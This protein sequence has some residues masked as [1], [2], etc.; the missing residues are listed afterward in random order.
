MKKGIILLF[1]AFLILSCQKDEPEIIGNG[2][3][4]VAEA[5]I[6]INEVLAE[7]RVV[8]SYE[9]INNDYIFSLVGGSS[10]LVI[11]ADIVASVE[12]Q[13]QQW[14]LTI[15]FT[16]GENCDLY[17]LGDSLGLSSSNV[18]LNPAG[19]SPLS[20]YASFETPFVGKI[21]VV[22]PG[23]TTVGISM[24]HTYD[25][26]TSDYDELPILGLYHSYSNPVEFHFLDI[27]ENLL[28][29]DTVDI[30]TQTLTNIPQFK[31]IQNNLPADE[32]MVYMEI[33]S[34]HAFDQNGDLRW[35]Y[36]NGPANQFFDRMPDG[37]W[38]V[39]SYRD[40]V[41]YHWPHFFEMDMFGRVIEEYEIPN[42]G[43]HEIRLADDANTFLI[44]S[45]SHKMT[46]G[47]FGDVGTNQEDVII[48]ISRETGQVSRSYDLNE[49][50]DNTRETLI[51][52]T[53][54]WFHANS[55]VQDM[56]AD[57]I[58]GTIDDAIIVSGRHQGTVAKINRSFGTLQWLISAHEGWGP[59]HQPY[60]LTPV[61]ESGSPIDISNINF[62]PYGQHSAILLPN[63]NVFVYDN[64]NNRGFYKENPKPENQ[65]SRAVEYKV[66]EEN[67][68]VEKVWEF[69]YNRQIFTAATGEVDYLPE[70]NGRLISF[71][72]ESGSALPVPRIV[73]LD[74]NDNVVFEYTFNEGSL[75]YRSD[76]FHLYE[77]IR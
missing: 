58:S 23:K 41:I 51:F 36:E 74:E 64:G 38:I 75:T 6:L 54:D 33:G 11:S 76:K 15:V 50:L 53:D 62:W 8:E 1:A 2:V 30:Q 72:W 48:E 12:T 22:V 42:L 71:M 67:M 61:D 69:D 73:E 46:F 13:R 32:D 66:N 56:G 63:G 44:C 65:Y 57:G 68:T 31:V 52:A 55:I 25:R 20:A 7:Y 29:I 26:N 18:V 21:K 47:T 37:N 59:E 70:T 27:E 4:T 3:R 14:K 49:I 34:R 5:K 10:P 40:I 9:V 19:R 77:G 43:H 24:E 45:N 35:V 60:L 16:D 39:S 17:L 28:S